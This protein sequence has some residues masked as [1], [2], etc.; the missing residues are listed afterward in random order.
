MTCKHCGE[1]IEKRGD[2]FVV[3]TAVIGEWEAYD[4]ECERLFEGPQGNLFVTVG[5]HEPSKNSIVIDILK[6][7]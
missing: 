3:I 4:S 5:Y 7:L 6:D 2:A 1:I